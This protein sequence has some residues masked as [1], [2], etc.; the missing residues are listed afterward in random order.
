MVQTAQR[1]RKY[2]RTRTH[3]DNLSTSAA[4]QVLLQDRPR[5]VSLAANRTPVPRNDLW[6]GLA[7]ILI[8]LALLMVALLINHS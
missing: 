2:R 3:L 1:S 7:F 6:H 4:W 8:G 5:V